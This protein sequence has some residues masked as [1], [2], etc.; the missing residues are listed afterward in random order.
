MEST[1][2]TTPSTESAIPEG[3]RCPVI[4]SFFDSLSVISAWALSPWALLSLL[5]QDVA[6][7]SSGWLSPQLSGGPAAAVLQAARKHLC[8]VGI[9]DGED[10]APQECCMFKWPFPSCCFSLSTEKYVTTHGWLS[11]QSFVGAS[12]WLSEQKGMCH[13]QRYPRTPSLGTAV[14]LNSSL[15][16][17]CV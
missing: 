1:A 3:P 4:A 9:W 13:A 15:S 6:E 17:S 8:Q 16:H 2:N 10:R 12:T 11:W 5:T 14:L 7:V